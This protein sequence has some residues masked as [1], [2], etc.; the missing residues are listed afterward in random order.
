MQWVGTAASS[1]I[2]WIARAGTGA[3]GSEL[4]Q[5]WRLA[6]G[7]E[8]WEDIVADSEKRSGLHRLHTECSVTVTAGP[9]PA[10]R[11]PGTLLK[12]KSA[13]QLLGNMARR[14]AGARGR[15]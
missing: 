2:G 15:S 11:D 14:P 1:A 13:A 9:R 10:N 12:T 8:R 7:S 6:Q 5:G 4:M 3:Q